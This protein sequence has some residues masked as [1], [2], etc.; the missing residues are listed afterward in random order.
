MRHIDYR[1]YTKSKVF[2]TCGHAYMPGF[3][4]YKGKSI[5]IL[6]GPRKNVCSLCGKIGKTHLH[7]VNGSP[8]DRQRLTIEISH[9]IYR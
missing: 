5:K 1:R 6:V 7:H 8:H 3:V 9:R 2:P 4:N